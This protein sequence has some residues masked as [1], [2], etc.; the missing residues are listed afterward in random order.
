VNNRYYLKLGDLF[1][2]SL[3]T[4]LKR[5]AILRPDLAVV[6]D[7]GGNTLTGPAFWPVA[8]ILRAPPR[9]PRSLRVEQI[10]RDGLVCF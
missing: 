7:P 4:H 5:W 1:S 10:N 9:P 3:V 6:I 2:G 8:A